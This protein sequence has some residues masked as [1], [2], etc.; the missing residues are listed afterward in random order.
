MRFFF[1]FFFLCVVTVVRFVLNYVR[2]AHRG[3]SGAPFYFSRLINLA[4][5]V[6]AAKIMHHITIIKNVYR[7]NQNNFPN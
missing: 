6:I 5:N 3:Y 2:C 7:V 1:L 4:S